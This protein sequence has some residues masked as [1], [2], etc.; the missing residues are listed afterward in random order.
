M[1]KSQEARRICTR[2]V[3]KQFFG[4]AKF[5]KTHHRLFWRGLSTFFKCTRTTVMQINNNKIFNIK[6]VD[7]KTCL[8]V[9][10]ITTKGKEIGQRTKSMLRRPVAY[11]GF[12]PM[13]YLSFRAWDPYEIYGR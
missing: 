7:K 1:P 12:W 2:G 4:N 8:V 9:T 5:I 10:I 6:Q 11:P 13:L 3:G